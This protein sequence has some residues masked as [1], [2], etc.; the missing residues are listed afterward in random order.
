M[1]EGTDGEVFVKKDTSESLFLEGAKGETLV[2]FSEGYS[3]FLLSELEED[4]YKKYKPCN[5]SGTVNYVMTSALFAK[6]L[7]ATFL[8]I[9]GLLPL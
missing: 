7:Q 4:A 1:K 6:H 2:L 8:S 3:D 5:E 9:L